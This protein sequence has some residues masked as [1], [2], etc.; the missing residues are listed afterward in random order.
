MKK[1][2][3]KKFKSIMIAEEDYEDFLK[4]KNAIEKKA[5]FPIKAKDLVPKLIKKQLEIIKGDVV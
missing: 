5:G 3:T 2:I 1:N 4:L